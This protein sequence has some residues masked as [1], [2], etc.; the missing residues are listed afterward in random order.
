MF[1]GFKKLDAFLDKYD[2]FIISTHESPDGDGLG[3]EIAFNE[4]LYCL[5]KEAVIL[6]SDPI[7]DKFLFID[8]DNEINIY[9]EKKD[10]PNLEE[11]AVFVLDTN[12]FD[13]IGTAYK[14]IKDRVK[15]VFIIDHHEGGQDKFEDNFIKAEASS[16]SEIIYDIIK[17]YKKKPSFKAAQAL[18]AGILFDTGSFRYPK[19]S[20]ETFRIIAHLVEIGANPFNIYEKIYESNSLDS[21]ELRAKML[22][23]MEIHFNRK[24]ILMKLT[25]EMLKET[26]A[27]FTEGELNINLPLTLEGVVASVLV[28]QNIGG[29]VKVS[30]R[31]KGDYDVAQIAM[32]K[33]GGGH[34]NAAGYKSKKSFNE[35]CEEVIKEMSAFFP[36]N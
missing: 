14:H 1:P 22:S 4:L 23:T 8:I 6:N 7:P 31:T 27:P 25:P 20:P 26:G 24:L 19:T 9:N 28:K 34:K 17:Y 2:K 5:N 33:G 35:T 29:E 11:Y 16:A 18:Y 21:F 12:D 15:D 13:N 30:M 3:A 36:A 32:D 10:F